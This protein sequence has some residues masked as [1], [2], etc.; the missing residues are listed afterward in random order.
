VFESALEVRG[1]PFAH[2]GGEDREVSL[3][4][5]A[6][7]ICAT[8]GGMNPD[9]WKRLEGAAQAGTRITIGPRLPVFDGA[10]RALGQ[11]FDVDR[12]RFTAPNPE[13]LPGGPRVALPHPHL[14]ALVEDVPAAADA[15]VSRAIDELSLPT[16]ACR[17]ESV[18]A[19]LHEDTSGE[20]RV[21]FVLNP[22]DSDVVATVT[23]GARILHAADALEDER[24]DVQNGVLE[25][26]MKPRTVRMIAVH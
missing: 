16:Y 25:V 18:F 3:D 23:V 7:I 26:R 9:L 14:A 13:S 5:A 6:W 21:V 19:T 2:V 15:A 8:S 20:P 4:G 17:P 12:L 1:V 22:G 11:P 24:F 10:F